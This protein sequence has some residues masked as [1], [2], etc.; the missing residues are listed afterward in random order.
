MVCLLPWTA[1]Y[2][3]IW[4]YTRIL[5][6]SAVTQDLFCVVPL[7]ESASLMERGLV[8]RRLAKVKCLKL[9][10]EWRENILVKQSLIGYK[11]LQWVWSKADIVHIFLSTAKDCGHLKTPSNGSFVGNLTTYPNKVQ[12]MCDEGFILRG[13]KIRLCL[14]TGKWSGNE[15]FCEGTMKFVENVINEWWLVLRNALE[16]CFE[17]F[18][19]IVG[20]ILP[21]IAVNCGGLSSPMNGSISGNLTVYPSI[22]TF[23]CD[24]GFI[25][26]GSSVRKC[27][28]NGTWH[29]HET[30]CEG[31][32][33][34]ATKENLERTFWSNSLWYSIQTSSVGMIQSWYCPHFFV[35]SK[36]LRPS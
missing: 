4:R 9:W 33:P 19:V 2:L 22:V 6:H 1:P 25:L 21:F 15:S 27:Q 24:P 17:E 26:R 13:S 3:V 16:K 18:S 11:R 35:N 23:S 34:K 20:I 10:K 5:S 28:S 30:T 36:R 14:S 32:M 29:G 31:K 12:F 7:Y 8:T